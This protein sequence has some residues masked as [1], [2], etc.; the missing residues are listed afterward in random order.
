ML[1][2]INIALT[3]III[4]LGLFINKIDIK[5]MAMI[6]VLMCILSAIYRIYEVLINVLC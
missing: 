5:T 4:L 6:C 3:C 1:S 2:V